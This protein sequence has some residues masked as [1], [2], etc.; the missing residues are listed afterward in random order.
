MPKRGDIVK[1]AQP[2]QPL[3]CTL[4]A[5]VICSKCNRRVCYNHWFDDAASAPF[6]K[7]CLCFCGGTHFMTMYDYNARKNK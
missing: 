6:M 4:N 2:D 5:I 1:L 7:M 3:C